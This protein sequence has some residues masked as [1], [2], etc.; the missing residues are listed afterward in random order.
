MTLIICSCTS[1]FTEMT[2]IV[3]RSHG[4]DGGNEPPHRPT[5]LGTNCQR[6]NFSIIL[7]KLD[8]YLKLITCYFMSSSLEFGYLQGLDPDDL[9]DLPSP[10]PKLGKA[11]RLFVG[12]QRTR[13]CVLWGGTPGNRWVSDSSLMVR[14]CTSMWALTLSG[15]PTWS[16][17]CYGHRFLCIRVPGVVFPSRRRS[18]S[19]TSCM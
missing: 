13:S 16:G 3:A 14:G 7:I 5:R 12:P 9:P 17:S 8:H 4:G 10:T 19:T 18:T 6:K 11:G 2:D 1:T 15:S